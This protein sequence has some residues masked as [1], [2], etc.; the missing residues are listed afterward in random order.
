M[1]D[2]LLRATAILNA[3]TVIGHA[4]MGLGNLFPVW[5]RYPAT[6]ER[7]AAKVGWSQGCGYYALSGTIFRPRA[8]A[9]ISIVKG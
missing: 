5:N 4:Q 9:T 6:K 8:F 2:P 7:T 3:I 1:A